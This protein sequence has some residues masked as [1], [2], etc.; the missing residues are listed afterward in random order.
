MTRLKKNAPNAELPKD[1]TKNE[2]SVNVEYQQTVMN[3]VN[4][5]RHLG[6]T[7]TDKS[8]IMAVTEKITKETP[9]RHTGHRKPAIKGNDKG[10]T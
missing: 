9:H 6:T 4:T 2:V 10:P 5:K 3:I 7:I 1:E 8:L